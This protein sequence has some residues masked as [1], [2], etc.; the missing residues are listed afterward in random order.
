[1]NVNSKIKT[2]IEHLKKACAI[3]DDCAIPPLEGWK[4]VLRPKPASSKFEVI[5]WWK[6][7]DEYALGP[8]DRI[9]FNI[10][11]SDDDGEPKVCVGAAGTYKFSAVTEV[12]DHLVS[13]LQGEV[14]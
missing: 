12:E 11:N 8:N 1:M 7:L 3:T 13:W 10:T 9:V 2:A 14:K 4:L 5:A 6:G